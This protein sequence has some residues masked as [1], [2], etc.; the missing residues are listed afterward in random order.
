ML[1]DPIR[2]NLLEKL[3][4]DVCDIEVKDGYGVKQ[5]IRCTLNPAFVDQCYDEFIKDAD[6]QSVFD[7]EKRQWTE[8]H[9]GDLTLFNSLRL[10]N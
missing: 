9:W 4:E 8:I 7:I 3:S 5:K 2:A 10:E 6:V 1:E